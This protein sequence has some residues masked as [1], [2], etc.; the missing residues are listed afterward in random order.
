M[1]EPDLD[2]F[3]LRVTLRDVTPTDIPFLYELQLDP[4]SNAMAAVKP[5]TRE[6]F[7]ARWATIFAEGGAVSKVILVQ[8]RSA[9][10]VSC[11][12]RDGLDWVGYFIAREFWGRGIATAALLLLLREIR[13]RPLYARAAR[14][15]GASIRVLEKC[16][17]VVTGYRQSPEDERFLAC[18]EAELILK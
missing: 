13:K 2:R 14:S 1:N 18:E 15:N 3:G 10:Q 17:F 8:G 11:F 6:A 4:A 5:R 9:G 12:V 16:G 7:E